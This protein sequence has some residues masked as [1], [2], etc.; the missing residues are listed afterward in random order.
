MFDSF[1]VDV[2]PDRTYTNHKVAQTAIHNIGVGYL[3]LVF[4]ALVVVL[5][6][7]VVHSTENTCDE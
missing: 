4:V 1:Y 6:V 3:S 2:Y 5:V 7:A